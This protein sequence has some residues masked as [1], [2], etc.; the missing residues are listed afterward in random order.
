MG[1]APTSKDGWK[2]LA[3]AAHYDS[4]E[5]A[6]LCRFSPRQLQRKFNFLFGRSPQNWLN[7][8]R[9]IAA[10][11]L[12]L[13]GEPIKTVAFDLGFKRV[14]HFYRQFKCRSHMTPLEFVSRNPGGITD[15][16]C[17]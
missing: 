4:K 13:S 14:S 2:A 11:Q 1:R 15:V 5:L 17:E 7:E 9:I 8:Q 3:V 16:V 6:K 12:L 10:Q